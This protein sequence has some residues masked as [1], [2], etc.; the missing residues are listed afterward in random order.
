MPIARA[1]IG[2]A[3]CPLMALGAIDNGSWSVAPAEQGKVQF[4]LSSSGAGRHF[5][6]S[7]DWQSADLRGLDWTTDAKHDVHFTIV[8]D[9][10][11]IDC[12]GFVQEQRGAGRFT[13]KPNQQYGQEMQKL[14]F[15]FKD[16]E[17]FSATTF[18]VSLEFVRALKTLSVQGLDAGKLVAF[19]IHGVSPAFIRDLRS[20]GLHANDADRLIA[21]RIHGVS[22]EFMQGLH[23]VGLDVT[24]EDKLIA[25]RIHGVSP[26]F[27]RGLASAGVSTNDPDELVALRIHEVTPTYI[28]NLRSKGLKNL[29]PD[30]LISMRIHDID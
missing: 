21:F 1:L 5:D 3:L 26:E 18:D 7:S 12:Q 24:D 28:E 25:F 9:A 10:G 8:R 2:L 15:S 27:I 22:S 17:L 13:F 4:S 14:G 23:G 19:R 16:D 29:T 30:Q 11:T 20:A 6:S